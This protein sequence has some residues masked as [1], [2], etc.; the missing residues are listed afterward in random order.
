MSST[1]CTA[2]III[3]AN[4]T[5]L[6]AAFAAIITGAFSAEDVAGGA[7]GAL[8]QGFKPAAFS[9]EAGVGS[10]S[11]AHSA[12][13]TNEPNAPVMLAPAII[14]LLRHANLKLRTDGERL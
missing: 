6:P 8:I 2:I 11:I 7:I 3:L 12:V 10:A 4:I 13:R 14:G 9:N 1:C 5:A